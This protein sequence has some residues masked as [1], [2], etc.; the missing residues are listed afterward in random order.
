VADADCASCHEEEYTEWTDSHH[1]LAMQEV[2]NQSVR[3]DFDDAT[4][5]H[6]GLTT[7]FFRR[8]D[9]FFVNT[10][11]PDGEL[12]DFEIAYV[13][14]LEPLQQYLVEFPGGRLQCLTVAWDTEAERWFTLYP[15]ERT[16]SDDSL[17]WTGLFQNWNT[18]CAECHSTQLEKNYDLET[19]S[20]R[21]TWVEI[22]VGCQACHGPGAEHVAWAQDEEA[23]W[24]SDPAEMGLQV[25]LRR[26]E[27]K[28]QLDSCSP[29]HSRRVRIEED[30]EYGGEFLDRYIPERLH[31]GYYHA[32]GQIL[33]EVYVYGSFVQSKMHVKGVS[34]TDCHDPHT[35]DLIQPG[36]ALCMQCH[37]TN[38]PQDRFPTLTQKDYDSPE[39]HFHPE[40][41][42]GAECV[43]CHMP[44][45]TYMQV[46]PRRDHS[47]RVPRPDLSV[48]LGTPNACNDCH[49]DQ[50]A[51]WSVDQVVA[52][53]PESSSAQHFANAF[54]SARAGEAASIPL[55]RE[56]ADD[57]EQAGIVR[58]TALDL[59]GIPDPDAVLSKRAAI[60]DP[61]PL[62]RS[63]AVRGLESL[64]PGVRA[65]VAIPL[66]DD[67]VR[68][69]RVEAA[70]ALAAIDPSLLQ[71]P[72][73]AAL[74]GALDEYVAAQ[75]INA[76]M[77]WAH[78]NL[79]AFAAERQRLD[80][81][82]Q[83]YLT[84]LRL[85]PNFLPARFNLANVYNQTGRNADAERVLRGGIERVPDEGELHYSLG[86]LLAE[87]ERMRE[88]VAELKLASELLPGRARVHH[89]LGL[90]YQ[91][92]ELW[93]EAER[94]HL[95][96]FG[97]N[98]DDVDIVNAVA[99]LLARRE[100]WHRAL[101]YAERLVQLAPEWEQARGLLE[102]IRAEVEVGPQR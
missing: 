45:R 76:D 36:N 71:P 81:A 46:D 75:T 14:G 32:D 33:E 77:P 10:E 42:T 26:G 66:L 57:P 44:Q 92:L 38:A 28:A 99:L 20:Y 67:P 93:E 90:A 12:A 2:S 56:V 98:S 61:D 80:V 64:P 55:L 48:A 96:A 9:A 60:E 25:P 50:S 79:G 21:T 5:E 74:E 68:A 65:A 82:E 62:V 34:C 39:H 89:N 59:L 100:Q 19:D 83:A 53:Y 58:A 27:A 52:W 31:A 13:F 47:F 30:Y 84:A 49:T 102:S 54:T 35:L 16:P 85:D 78:L 101:P 41:S 4:F 86:L 3:G 72:L 22:D 1:D 8:G 87:E 37:S 40:D 6:M 18:M 7:R 29:C 97:Q 69:V 51:Q 70:R 95:K 88:A 94:A 23:A 24:M 15:D 63:A 91:A 43:S 73:R 11:G 17:H